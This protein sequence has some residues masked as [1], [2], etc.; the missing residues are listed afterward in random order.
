MCPQDV[1]KHFEEMGDTSPKISSMLSGICGR[2]LGIQ[3]KESHW[4]EALGR[5]HY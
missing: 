3:R 1:P 2:A 5:L 4:I